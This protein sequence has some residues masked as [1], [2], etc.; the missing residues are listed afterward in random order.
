MKRLHMNDIH[1]L[2]YGLHRRQPVVAN[3]R[4]M[5]HARKRIWK[6]CKFPRKDGSAEQQQR[7]ACP[8]NQRDM[9]H[10]NLTA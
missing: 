3:H 10:K 5:G 6:Y 1:E 8:T 7:L 2:I 4:D 9:H